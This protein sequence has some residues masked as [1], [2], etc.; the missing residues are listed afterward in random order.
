[1]G[2]RLL[3]TEEELET[4]SFDSSNLFFKPDAVALPEKKEEVLKILELADKYGFYVVSRGSGTATTGSCLPILGGLVISLTRMNRI[5]ELNPEDRTVRVEPGVLNGDLKNYLKRYNFFY[6][7]DPASFA[8][9]TIGGNVATGAGGPKGLKYGTTKDYVLALEVALPGGHL[10]KT[11]APTLKG[12]VPYNLT[13]LFVGSEGTLGIFVEII[14]KLLPLPEKR[15][16]FLIFFTSEEEALE[17]VI[18]LITKGLTPA[19]AEFVD[20]TSTLVCKENIKH[21]KGELNLRNEIESLLFLEIDGKELE[22]LEESK[23]VEEILKTKAI[24]YIKREKEDDLENLWEIRRNISPSLKRLATKK[25]AE[26][27]VVPRSKMKTFLRFLREL[28][29][30]YML[31]ISAFGHVGDG[32]FHVNILYE[33]EAR[34]K[35]CKVRELILK[36]VLELHGTISGEHGIGY[37]KRSYVRWEIDPLQIEIM[38]KIKNVF[39]PKGLL[40]P[41]I[42]LP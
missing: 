35:A 21:L 3:T 23:L 33:E 12:V 10:L 32:N 9:S 11:G 36:K 6:P 15:C 40:N 14:L 1:M 31:F 17:I 26:D 41:Q 19:S 39:D 38:K 30:K 13:P 4:Y 25:M 20:K 27:I 7:P 2:T 37:L 34:A 24:A 5:L 22:V 29:K 42:K 28:E 8:F 18:E 16:L